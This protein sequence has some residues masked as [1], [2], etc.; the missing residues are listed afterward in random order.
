MSLDAPGAN[1]GGRTKV[2][3][4]GS[5]RTAAIAVVVL[6]GA[7]VAAPFDRDVQNLAHATFAAPGRNKLLA[8]SQLI[9]MQ[10]LPS[11]PC[12]VATRPRP[13]IKLTGPGGKPIHISVEQITSVRSDTEIPGSRTILDLTSGK[14]QAVQESVE[15]VMALIAATSA[16]REDDETPSADLVR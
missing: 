1:D 12:G 5:L 2:S 4:P 8:T 7:P 14:F 6:T 16:T 10:G 11:Y 15:Q 13:W 9:R 3:V